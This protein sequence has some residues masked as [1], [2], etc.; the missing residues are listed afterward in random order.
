MSEIDPT[1]NAAAAM[2]FV[3][4]AEM[5]W[6]EAGPEQLALWRERL[7]VGLANI[8]SAHARTEAF[9]AAGTLNPAQP[10]VLDAYRRIAPTVIA[11][12]E[13]LLANI[14]TRLCA[15]APAA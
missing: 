14:T 11:R 8:R 6:Q 12:I 10:S 13:T 9:A 4:Q 1:R 5:G 15:P 7:V 2:Q 3:R